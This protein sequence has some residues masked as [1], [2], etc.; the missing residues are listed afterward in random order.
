M[1]LFSKALAVDKSIADAQ[2]A[3]E[4]ERPFS[5]AWDA[6]MAR[7]ED[8]ERVRWELEREVA[9]AGSAFASP[10]TDNGRDDRHA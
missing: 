3:V 5:P 1:Q 10:D 6:A 7:L 4:R 2:R 8:A 9:D